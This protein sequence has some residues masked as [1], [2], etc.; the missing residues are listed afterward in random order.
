MRTISVFFLL[1]VSFS[2]MSQDL[3]GIWRGKLTQEPGG[4]YLEYNIELQINY[5]PTA[6]TLNGRAYDFYD[7]TKYVKLDFNGRFNATTKRMVIIENTL[8][9]SKI[10]V[11]CVPCI[12]TY[13]LTWSKNGAEEV[14]IGE[15]KGREFGGNNSCPSYKIILKRAAQSA[16]VVDV[17]QTPELA[18]LQ[19]KLN[20]KPREKEL[21]RTLTI[22][23]SAIRLDFYDNAEIDGD[24]ITVL[25]NN[26]LLLYRKMLTDK[27]LT[28]YVNAF[29][30][31]DYE[32]VMYADNLGTIPPNTALMMVTAGDKKYEVRLSSSEQKSATV[33][34]RYDKRP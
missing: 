18:A 2:V 21:V 10:P 23:T 5:I 11:V 29:P 33:R 27:P 28:V 19:E 32:L 12:K 6:N 13:D 17:N 3:N 16:F 20:L 1:L 26:K 8:M 25:L 4:C 34:F 30:G 7:I 24:T 14:L 22:D 31:T 15:C 9:E